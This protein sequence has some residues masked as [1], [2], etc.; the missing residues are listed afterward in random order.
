MESSSG[1]LDALLH[2]VPTWVTTSL[3]GIAIVVILVVYLAMVV[4][5]ELVGEVVVHSHIIAK[6]TL[7]MLSPS[8]T[9]SYSKLTLRS[10][11]RPPDA[12]A[13]GQRLS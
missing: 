10:T 9:F 7:G 3:L 4:C 6:M 12:S 8:I 13:Q 5:L 1:I 11:Q 2:L